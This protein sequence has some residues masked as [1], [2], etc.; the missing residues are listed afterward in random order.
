MIHYSVIDVTLISHDW[1]VGYVNLANTLIAEYGGKH[2][3]RTS[4]HECLEGH[5]TKPTFRIIIE[6]PSR[7]AAI[8][9]MND[10]RYKTILDA[11]TK[12]TVSN[13]FLIEGRDDLSV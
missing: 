4:N 11:R 3:A 2:L 5:D 9:F 8:G 13:H 10:E 1:I 7:E 6:W 12:G